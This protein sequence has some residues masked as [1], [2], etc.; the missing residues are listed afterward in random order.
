MSGDEPVDLEYVAMKHE[1]DKA[2][3]FDFGDGVE[4]W[5]PKSQIEADDGE[6]NVVVSRWIAEQKDLA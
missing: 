4:V 3:L 6:G 5:L 1:T 2:K